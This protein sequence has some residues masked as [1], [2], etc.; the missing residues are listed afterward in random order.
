MLKAEAIAQAENIPLKYLLSILNGL[1][2]ASIVN[3]Q[4]GSDGGY[5]LA[6]SPEDISV[7]DVFGAVEGPLATRSP[8]R[9][10]PSPPGNHSILPEVWRA[11]GA[12]VDE[13]LRAVSL[14]DLARG[15]LPEA[16]T[17]AR[18][19]GPGALPGSTTSA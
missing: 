16:V 13:V 9:D 18:S 4:R 7:A 2:Q 5:S 6:R 10:D 17:G 11:V 1:R 3:S 14:A 12:N 19:F 15:T 8:Q